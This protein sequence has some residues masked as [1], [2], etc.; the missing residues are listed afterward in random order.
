MLRITFSYVSTVLA[1]WVPRKSP[2]VPISWA[3]YFDPAESMGRLVEKGALFRELL[4]QGLPP[5][6]RS[7][8]WTRPV[9]AERVLLGVGPT[10]LGALSRDGLNN[11]R[12][13]SLRPEIIFWG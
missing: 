4:V 3:R 13:K 6:T 11:Y 2:I 9:F 10:L 12:K 1:L 7:S 8:F 5:G